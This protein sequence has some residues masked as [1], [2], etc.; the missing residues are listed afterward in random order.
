MKPPDISLSE[1]LTERSARVA[2]AIKLQRHP[3]RRRARRFLA[4][5]PNLVE[6][7]A[8]RDLV[9][10]VFATE[11]AAQRYAELLAGLVVHEV[12]ERAAKA[13]S[14]T[15]TPSGLIAVCA[16]PDDD[17]ETVLAGRPQLVVVAVELSEP[18]NAGTLIRLADAMGASAVVFAGHSV[19][20]YNGKV[21]RSSAGSIF[22]V[23]VVIAVETAD[24]L[25]GLR[26][27]GLQLLAT[28]L[29]GELSLDDADEVLAAPTAWVFGPEAH[30]L[31]AEIAASA[32]HRVTI[33][34]P[35]GAESLNVAAAAAICL[36][37][38][39]R[40]QRRGQTEP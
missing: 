26:D 22:A 31:S 21:L 5:G 1:A 18:G 6:A 11:V 7:A 24:V 10:E 29:D 34:M 28:T 17:L 33:P 9:V 13:L 32:D 16:L 15:V 35:G 2:A 19:D 36:Y 20:P 30:G 39:A 3:G 14:E 4:E 38:S 25:S 40:A 8:R 27:A 23:P 12:T 37:Q